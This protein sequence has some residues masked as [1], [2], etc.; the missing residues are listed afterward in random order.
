MPN[1]II[2]YESQS[3]S[4]TP[5]PNTRA[6]PADMGAGIG[7]AIAGVGQDITQ[8]SDAMRAHQDREDGIT[9][10]LALAQARQAGTQQLI[11]MENSPAAGS[12]GFAGQYGSWFDDYQQKA[13]NSIAVGDHAQKAWQVGMANLKAEFMDRAM[14]SQASQAAQLSTQKA[15]DGLS[16]YVNT[17]ATDPTQYDQ[18]TAAANK[19]IDGLNLKPTDTQSL[20]DEFTN[21]AI[22][23]R[24][25]SLFRAAKT[26]AAVQGIVNDLENGDWKTKMG[27]TQFNRLLT[28]AHSEQNS[29]Q[30][31]ANEDASAAIASVEDRVKNGVAIDPNEWAEVKGKVQLSTSPIT[32]DKFVRLQVQEDTAQ[33][34]K[35]LSTSGLR[36]YSGALAAGAQAPM[37]A[38]PNSPTGRAQDGFT[39]LKSK[40][41]LDDV[42]AMG[43]LANV[44]RETGF[45]PR[46]G[47]GGTSDGYFQW[48]N[49][50]MT[51]AGNAGALGPDI[52]R[53]IDFAMSEPQGQKYLALARSGQL[54]NVDSASRA[55]MQ[56]FELPAHPDQDQP[57]NMQWAQRITQAINGG[58][59]LSAAGPQGGPGNY[60]SEADMIRIHATNQE[61]ARRDKLISQGDQMTAAQ[62]AGLFTLGQLNTPQDFQQRAQQSQL[63]QGFLDAK[64]NKPFTPNETAAF[65]QV[66]QS[67]SIQ[68]KQALLANVAS[69]G[70]AA[71]AAFKEIGEKSP[72]FAHIGGLT[73]NGST[74]VAQDVM[75]GVQMMQDNPDLKEG[76]KAKG[77]GPGPGGTTAVFAETAGAAM[78]NLPQDAYGARL[79][80]DALYVQRTGPGAPWNGDEYA[81]A[82]RDVLGS[83][84]GD[85]SGGVASINGTPTVM[86]PGVSGND[87]QTMIHNLSDQDLADH[88][89][90]GGPPLDIHGRPLTAADISSEGHFRATAVGQ[91][92][93]YLADGLPAH[94]TGP[95]N[96]YTFRIDAKG[97][98]AIVQRPQQPST[99]LVNSLPVG[100]P[101]DFL[102]GAANAVGGALS[103]AGHGIAAGLHAMSHGIK[104]GSAPAE[105]A[106]P[107]PAPQAP[108]APEP[109]DPLTTVDPMGNFT[110]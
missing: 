17:I 18:A 44:G 57:I 91:Y 89:V 20:R 30:K 51:A 31:V 65:E 109:N 46:P 42:S 2:P 13:G 32:Q 68:E 73:A 9:A 92:N 82:V 43:V 99:P 76:L 110:Q 59:P 54:G 67:G 104:M 96:L 101:T 10:Q 29:V 62:D 77:T 70:S 84:P 56:V 63:A 45:Q 49:E 105:P 66:M 6:T 69:M 64:E 107:A 37:Q 21:N 71:P 25:D 27:D 34:V 72:V 100:G 47:D 90:G 28:F 85:A 75:R 94:G 23:A 106:A 55:W 81:K 5:L 35:G 78:A 86:P 40:Y 14:Q 38:T 24:F 98:E 12:P 80:A 83:K 60:V 4:E 33:R 88:S 61:I 1:N 53:A 3:S 103:T 8:L 50:R 79:A 108:A 39:Y 16:T 41:G 19:M 11:Q 48:H 87:F 7:Q 95:G 74:N 36:D 15:K 93:V 52:K 58:R 102:S 26:P 22:A 97:V